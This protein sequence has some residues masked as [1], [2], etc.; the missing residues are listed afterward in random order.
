MARPLSNALLAGFTKA[1]TQACTFLN[2]I[3]Q[4]PIKRNDGRICSANLQIYFGTSKLS[5]TFFGC[6]HE[7]TGDALPP[8]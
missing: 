6:G 3:A 2:R 4:G 1:L 8:M 7:S 5:Q